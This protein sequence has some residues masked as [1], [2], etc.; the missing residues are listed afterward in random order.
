MVSYPE[1]VCS[2]REQIYLRLRAER[3]IFLHIIMLSGGSGKRLWPLSNDLR[4]KQY[5]KVISHEDNSDKACSMVQRVWHQLEKANLNKNCIITASKGQVEIIK[6][7]LGNVDIAVEPERRDTFPAIMLSLSY[8][9]SK[10]SAKDNDVVAVIPVDPYT[11]QEYFEVLSSLEGVL[12]KSGAEIALMGA[13]PSE[14]SEKFGYIVPEKDYDDWLSVS[15]FEEKPSPERAEEL[16]KTGALWNCGVFCFRVG[17]LIKKLKEYGLSESYEDVYKNYGK[18]PKTSFDYA[19]LE[20]AKSICVAK[21]NTMWKDLGTWNALCEQMNRRSIGNAVIHESCSN[22][23][24]LNELDIPIVAMGTKDTIISASFDGI[25]VSD[26]NTST[27]IKEC[28]EKFNYPPMYEERRWGT[29]KVI[30]ITKKKNVYTTTRKIHI[31]EQMNSS[32]H[33]HNNRD[34]V[35]TILE[36]NGEIIINGIKQLLTTGDVIRIPK[37]TKHAIRS[38]DGIY[39]IEVQIGKT[40]AD[41]DI[42]RITFEWDEIEKK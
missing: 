22:T 7:Q 21:L 23:N 17:S 35:W 38:L 14:P 27:R 16:I 5:I 42:N 25:L 2:A 32:Y 26:K 19:V 15:H 29:I 6:S 12:D 4:S 3:R 11:Q 9:K 20:K 41:S 18:L 34:E 37:G 13:T 39:F 24:I 33:F 10:L 31:F 28:V 1:F 40:V 36:G 8:L 30:D